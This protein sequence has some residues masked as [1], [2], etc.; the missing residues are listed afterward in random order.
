MSEMAMLRQLQFK[1][2]QIKYIPG[3]ITVSLLIASLSVASHKSE[4]NSVPVLTVCEALAHASEYDGKVVQIRDRVAGGMEGAAFVGPD[5][6]GIF[7]TEHKKW[8][9]AI[10]W[11][12]PSQRDLIVHPVA[13]SF[14]W[15]SDEIL[16]KRWAVLRK[17]L[18]DRCIAATY[19]GMFESMSHDK[20]KKSDGWMIDGFGHLNSAP[21]QL[22]LK[23]A[24]DVSPLPNCK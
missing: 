18:P 17:R 13:F 21:A 22:V 7:V 6:P 1:V 2:M 11:T 14:D 24:D 12:M 15:S 4:V 3:I 19:T 23:S 20:L 8:P 5:C 9:S 16:K 10:V